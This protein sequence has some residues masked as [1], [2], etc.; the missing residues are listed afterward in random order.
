MAPAANEGIEQIWSGL[1][2]AR[3]PE[4]LHVRTANGAW[5]PRP[6]VTL[7][8]NVNSRE[9]EQG[10]IVR[11]VDENP[12][13]SRACQLVTSKSALQRVVPTLADIHEQN[14]VGLICFWLKSM[15]PNV[16]ERCEACEGAAQLMAMWPVPH[17]CDVDSH[18]NRS[19]HA[20]TP[21]ARGPRPDGRSALG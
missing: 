7:S 5:K 19:D 9:H 21:I 17:S 2:N 1:H 6:P 11:V 20:L 3:A 12:P 8:R 14:G 4:K 18:L 13:A 16:V 10:P 15:L